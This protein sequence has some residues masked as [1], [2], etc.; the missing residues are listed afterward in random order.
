MISTMSGLFTP[1]PEPSFETNI[2]GGTNTPNS[3]E[4][5]SDVAISKTNEDR[6]ERSGYASKVANLISDTANPRE[7]TIYGLTGEWGSGKTS[8][9]NLVRKHLSH[10]SDSW[11]IIDYNPWVA[12]DPEA[13]IEE[14]YRS[15]MEALPSNAIGARIK[16]LLRKT[17]RS[18]GPVAGTL[19]SLGFL[20]TIVASKIVG[21]VSIAKEFQEIWQPEQDSWPTLYKKASEE[22]KRLDKQILLVV[23]DIDRLHTDELALLMKVVRLLGRFP[24]VNYLLVYDEES[25]LATLMESTAIGGTKDDALRFMEKIVQYPL[26]VPPLTSDQIE[27]QLVTMLD[28]LPFEVHNSEERRDL[29]IV[30]REMFEVWEKILTT[31]RALRRYAALLLNWFKIYNPSEVNVA[32]VIILAT[33]RIA[34]PSAYAKIPAYKDSLLT[35]RPPS[36]LASPSNENNKNFDWKST[37][38][39]DLNQQQIKALEPM[40]VLLFPK[41]KNSMIIPDRQRRSRAISTEVYFDTYLLFQT[42][43]NVIS[44]EDLK[45]ILSNVNGG[46]TVRLAE[47]TESVERS[48]IYSVVAKMPEAIRS[49]ENDSEKIIAAE[50]LITT[51]ESIKNKRHYVRMTSV[52][53]EFYFQASLALSQLHSLKSVNLYDH[54]FRQTPLNSAV[55]YLNKIKTHSQTNDSVWEQTQS[56][57]ELYR[58]CG[59]RI[60]EVLTEK[61]ADDRDL[62]PYSLSAFTQWQEFDA[63][64]DNLMEKLDAGDFDVIDVGVLFL[65]TAYVMGQKPPQDHISTFNSELFTRYISAEKIEQS[66]EDQKQVDQTFAP[67]DLSWAGR[68]KAVRY[69]LTSGRTSFHRERFGGQ[70]VDLD[71]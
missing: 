64:H 63:F 9:V 55:Y 46:G 60:W 43:R 41:L 30:Q 44:D 50:I 10:F 25:L 21:A 32:D 34:F 19:E 6:F 54:F 69:A 67:E 13:L 3:F 59:E 2:N 71:T 24:R 12:S 29:R 15:I 47:L 26:D 48:Q 57:A 11:E 35:N 66:R 58:R 33:I 31:P 5:W 40:L 65:T 4:S 27:E 68:R 22:F 42:P 23:D 14:F 8:L 45:D 7:S 18:T 28:V 53:D 62:G 61:D 56:Y 70:I 17:V 16:D 52:Y 38:G 51:A 1:F 36:S 49:L 39:E 37:L 20:E